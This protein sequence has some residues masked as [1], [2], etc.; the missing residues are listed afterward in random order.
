V[1]VLKAF[2]IIG[3]GGL[4]ILAA[5]LLISEIFKTGTGWIFGLALIIFVTAGA[6]ALVARFIR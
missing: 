3:T 4:G 1:S 2:G 5:G 6:V